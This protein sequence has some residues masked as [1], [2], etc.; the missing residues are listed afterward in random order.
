M[1]DNY[2]FISGKIQK[3]YAEFSENH[4][5]N[6]FE[7]IIVRKF[8]ILSDVLQ[9]KVNQ[10]NKILKISKIVVAALFLLFTVVAVIAGN[11]YGSKMLWFSFWIVFIFIDVF[12]FLIADYFK[13]VVFKRFM[14]F[15]NNAEVMD[16]NDNVME[17]IDD[18]NNSE[19][20]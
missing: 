10:Y 2:D 18:E 15:I 4:I 19:N 8:Y 20:L 9:E 14:R 7:S 5:E 3:D 11:H 13:N 1:I 16:F 17:E 12:V 6:D